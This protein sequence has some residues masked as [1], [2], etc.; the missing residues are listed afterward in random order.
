MSIRRPLQSVI[1]VD[2]GHKIFRF[3][4]LLP[5]L[6][7]VALHQAYF[8]QNAK[9]WQFAMARFIIM[10]LYLNTIF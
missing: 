5:F 9:T 2:G 6:S 3:F 10:L 1:K 7:L 8:N 4:F